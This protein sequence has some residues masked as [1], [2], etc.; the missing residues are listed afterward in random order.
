MNS[1]YCRETLIKLLNLT[2]SVYKFNKDDGETKKK[3]YQNFLLSRERSRWS[4]V[5]RW[6]NG[7]GMFTRQGSQGML[8]REHVR[9]PGTLRHDYVSTQDTL[10]SEHVS[11]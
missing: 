3:W 6:S 11:T 1:L 9:S 5:G 7:H 4:H 10:V 8:V 2:N